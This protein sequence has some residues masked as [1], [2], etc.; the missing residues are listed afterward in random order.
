MVAASTENMPDLNS[1]VPLVREEL[2]L[3]KVSPGEK[4]AILTE[5]GNFPARVRA[6][7]IAIRELGAQPVA[8]NVGASGAGLDLSERLEN[9]GTSALASD[10]AAFETLKRA[11]MVIEYDAASVF[12]RA[13]CHPGSRYAHPA[14]RRAARNA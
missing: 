9:L 5:G 11:D 1:M 2:K 12:E 13:A 10:P 6:F 7:E 8:V 14:R 4:I 3:C